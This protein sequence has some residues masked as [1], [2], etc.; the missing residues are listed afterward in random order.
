[1]FVQQLTRRALALL[2][3]AAIIAPLAVS[4]SQAGENLNSAGL[5]ASGLGG[6]SAV[7][8]LGK[9]LSSVAAQHGMTETELRRT[10]LRDKTLRLSA[11]GRLF[12]V[13]DAAQVPKKR[14]PSDTV[15]DGKLLPLGETFNLH[16]KPGSKRL[17]IMNFQGKNITNTY[18][19]SAMKKPVIVATPFNY[20]SDPTTFND[21]ERTAIQLIWQRVAE[22]F[23]AFDVDVTTD[24]NA[25]SKAPAGSAYASVVITRQADYFVSAPGIATI[26]TFGMSYYEPAFAAY[27]TLH[28]NV[29]YIAECISHEFGHRL[30]LLH[31]GT[32]TLPYYRGQG[33]G[34][35]S[36]APIMGAGYYTNVTQ[37]SRGEY[38]N[39]NNKQDDF[40]V[41][42]RFLPLR[43]DAAG[44]TAGEAA[45]FPATASNGRSSGSINGVIE[46][47]GDVDL[48]SIAA[49]SGAITAS[50][51]VAALGPDVK[52]SLSLVDDS[53]TAVLSNTVGTSLNA[54]ISG[55]VARPG[56]YYL[57]V[58]ATGYGNPATNG[59]SDYG[60]RGFYRLTASYPAPAEAPPQA[61]IAAVPAAGI[62]PLTVAFSRSASGGS[63]RI[64]ANSWNFGN[65]STSTAASARATYAQPGLY[66]AQ[67]K[68]TDATGFSDV[69]S[70]QIIVGKALAPP[71][72][73]I[74]RTANPNGT[75]SATV[76]VSELA[77]GAGNKLVPNVVHG[78]WG[79]A[80][81]AS[82]QST[83]FAMGATSFVSPGTANASDC[84]TFRLDR[85]DTASPTSGTAYWF[86][87]SPRTVSTCPQQASR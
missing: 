6:T 41:I 11:N 46:N 50:A 76:R 61:T 52:L 43:A 55:T 78:T 42:Q 32:T 44:S 72:L 56:T 28:R 2:G 64:A 15:L 9:N 71:T 87:P 20:D 67:M 39:A 18:W 53:G 59:F 30:G 85:V 16:S 7:A 36:W 79:G 34:T 21:Q 10:L 24:I 69:A 25:M 17:L 66:M 29:K 14:A 62:A 75:Y 80:L 35:T 47:Q 27:D 19:N 74:A 33:T 1:M 45:D 82:V 37:F 57:R 58:S 48:F 49:G 22:D 70:K 13:E 31:D 4:A 60:S 3:T 81:R 54:T 65:G 12:Y 84:I 26:N 63:G 40:A 83:A 77:D 68:V 23:A 86:T 8:A 51:T 38:A 73:T 5:S